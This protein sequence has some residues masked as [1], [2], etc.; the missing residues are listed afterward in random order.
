[1]SRLVHRS[2]VVRVKES[3]KESYKSHHIRVVISRVVVR[4]VV[5]E[6][7]VEIIGIVG[8]VINYQSHIIRVVS[9][10]SY[11]QSRI[12]RVVVVPVVMVNL[13]TLPVIITVEHSVCVFSR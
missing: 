13:Y 1:M 12:I 5:S 8:I 7:F 10:E 11:Y 9:S 4:V 2:L 6:S 3:N